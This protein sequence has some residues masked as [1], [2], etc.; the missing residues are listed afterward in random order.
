MPTMT[1]EQSPQ[2]CCPTHADS[3]RFGRQHVWAGPYLLDGGRPVDGQI[4]SHEDS[5]KCHACG[6]ICNAE[7]TA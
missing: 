6:G 7:V 5:V 1:T 3:C 2:I 4:W